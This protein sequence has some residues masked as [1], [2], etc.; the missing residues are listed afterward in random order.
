ME[1]P[2]WERF[3]DEDY[4]AAYAAIE[5][6]TPEEVEGICQA[7]LLPAGGHILDLCCGYGRVA[8]P[9]AQRG[10]TVTGQDLT[11]CFLGLAGERA[12]KAG[13]QLRLVHSDMREIP[14]EEEFDAVINIFTSFGFFEDDR[15]NEKVLHEVAKALK[16]GGKFLIDLVHREGIMRVFRPRDWQS[17]PDGRA[18]LQERVWDARRGVMNE[19]RMLLSEHGRREIVISLRLYNCVELERMLTAAGLRVTQ[20]WGGL[21]LSE[22]TMD[23]RRLVLLAEKP[24]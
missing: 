6:G 12:E 14:F 20:V 1:A 9:L 13:V 7:L 5:D 3:F 23:S 15:E 11:E 8:I 16:P 24:E 21:D 10:Y 18:H 17:L 22:L 4:L 19:R 2:W